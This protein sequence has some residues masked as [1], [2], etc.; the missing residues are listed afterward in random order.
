M[1]LTMVQMYQAKVDAA[2]GLLEADAIART[3]NESFAIIS[4]AERQKL[5]DMLYDVALMELSI[6]P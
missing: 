1:N 5:V 3:K 6:L 2:N 4:K